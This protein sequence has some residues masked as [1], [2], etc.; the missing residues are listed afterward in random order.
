MLT[1]LPEVPHEEETHYL[2]GTF[3]TQACPKPGPTAPKRMLDP[4]QIQSP[5]WIDLECARYT[6]FSSVKGV[7]SSALNTEL[8]LAR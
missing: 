4:L 8:F 1:G 2:C 7:S 6:A 5:P 3:R